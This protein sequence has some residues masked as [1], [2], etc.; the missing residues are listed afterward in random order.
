[1]E[2]LAHKYIGQRLRGI[3]LTTRSCVHMTSSLNVSLLFSTLSGPWKNHQDIGCT[4]VARLNMYLLSLV[5]T[6]PVKAQFSQPPFQN[7]S[8]LTGDA[9]A[10]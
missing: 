2:P 6:L 1:M 4:A 3:E 10:V 9:G 7:S 5:F 8:M